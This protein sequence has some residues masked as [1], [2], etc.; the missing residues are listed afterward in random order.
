M[1][2]KSIRKRDKM[3]IVYSVEVGNTMGA[4]D[5]KLKRIF[6][7]FYTAKEWALG[8]VEGDYSDG[9]QAWEAY[10][11]WNFYSASTDKEA[12]IQEWEVDD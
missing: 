8:E 4:T 12:T 6:K 3:T 1:P 2:F 9:K 10:K 7:S 5:V 11:T